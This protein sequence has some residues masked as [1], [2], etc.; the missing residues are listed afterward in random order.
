LDPLL[1]NGRDHS[2][3][4]AAGD[5]RIYLSAFGTPIGKTLSSQRHA[6]HDSG[7]IGMKK[8]SSKIRE[9]IA[10]LQEQLKAGGDP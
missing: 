4:H 9:E 1:R 5:C 7:D 2:P 3:K 6:F 8:P 10:K